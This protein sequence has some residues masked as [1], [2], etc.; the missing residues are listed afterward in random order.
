MLTAL[1][2]AC[3]NGRALRLWHTQALL[4]RLLGS[5]LCTR[6]LVLVVHT[7]T[8]QYRDGN[9]GGY[10]QAANAAPRAFLDLGWHGFVGQRS[11]HRRGDIQVRQQ[12]LLVHGCTGN[13]VTRPGGTGFGIIDGIQYPT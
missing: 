5:K 13:L 7:H 8:G 4:D 12:Q 11:G 1:T 10:R 9:R 2:I 6:D 3:Q